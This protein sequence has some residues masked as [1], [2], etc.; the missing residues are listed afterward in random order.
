MRNF[1][2][3][4]L[5]IILLTN[6]FP[7]VSIGT[8]NLSVLS[9]ALFFISLPI[10]FFPGIYKI[11]FSYKY[12]IY[13]I[14]LLVFLIINFIK[15]IQLNVDYITWLTRAAFLISIPFFLFYIFSLTKNIKLDIQIAFQILIIIGFFEV[16]LII[17]SAFL[18]G[19]PQ[20]GRATVF[21]GSTIYS[22]CV[23][24]SLYWSIQKYKVL[25]SVKYLLLIFV[26][27]VALVLTGSRLLFLAG[28]LFIVFEFFNYKLIFPA[29]LLLVS[30][31][32]YLNDAN[33]LIARS[34]NI[35]D[36]ITV[37]GKLAEIEYMK[38]FFTQNPIFGIGLGYPFNN[39]IDIEDFTY[40]HNLLAF[41]LG[42]GGVI[43]FLL[44]FSPIFLFILKFRLEGLKFIFP[45]ILFNLSTTSYNGLRFGLL[46]S[47]ILI[48]TFTRCSHKIAHIIL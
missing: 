12:F 23:L 33:I 37:L 29:V 17:L 31:F 47:L 34:Q 30:F 6:S 3:I 45:I 41:S 2:F 35:E 42:Y 13:V 38:E 21:L 19:D 9:S 43:L 32:Y 28:I 25:V 36:D 5:L 15:S 4:L 20:S 11:K 7:S 44:I 39:G 14:T 22:S 46:F 1:K 48:A 27:I 10:Y 16:V 26:I 24:V 8:L 40:T 18:G